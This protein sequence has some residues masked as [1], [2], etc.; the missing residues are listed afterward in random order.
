MEG[1]Q[2]SDSGTDGRRWRKL[3]RSGNSRHARPD[4]SGKVEGLQNL[5]NV[6]EGEAHLPSGPEGQDR[7]DARGLHLCESLCC[8]DASSFQ[9]GKRSTEKDKSARWCKDVVECLR[10]WKRKRSSASSARIT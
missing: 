9:D 8:H 4:V 10:R 6:V 5:H 2:S 1:D 7:E 3:G